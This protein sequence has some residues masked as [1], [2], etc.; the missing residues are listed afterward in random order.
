L[1]REF[2]RSTLAVGGDL[3]HGLGRGASE[4]R[5]SVGELGAVAV[6][7]DLMRKLGGSSV[8]ELGRARGC[9]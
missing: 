1:V 8:R 4:H 7:G 6:G 5:G 2:G 9:R 3:V